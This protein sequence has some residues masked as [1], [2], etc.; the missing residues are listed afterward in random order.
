MQEIKD[1][2]ENI[3]FMGW[4]IIAAALFLPLLIHKVIA[5]IKEAKEE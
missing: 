5:I 3:S 1:F 4:C 2:I